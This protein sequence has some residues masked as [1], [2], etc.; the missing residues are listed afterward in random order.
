MLSNGLSLLKIRKVF[1]RPDQ[2]AALLLFVLLIGLGFMA[3]QWRY[4]ARVI[5]SNLGYGL[6][7]YYLA[8]NQV[9][10][11]ANVLQTSL[12]I[13]LES[14]RAYNDLGYI[15]YRRGRPH[16]AWSAFV[17]A[18]EADPTFS[19]AYNNL[20]LSYLQTGQLDPA[21]QALQQAIT[22]NPENAS[23]WLNLGIGEQRAG[24][25]Q[26]AIRAYRSALRLDP[27]LTVAQ[28]NLGLIYFAEGN[29]VEAEQYLTTSLQSQPNLSR[30]RIFRGAIALHQGD[31]D[32]AWQEFQA[33]QPDLD[34]DP[35]LHFYLGLWYEMAEMQEPA[36]E[37]FNKVLALNPNG[38]LAVLVQSHL[39]VLTM[40]KVDN[41]PLS[42]E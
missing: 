15:Y 23:A 42:T 27:R 21:R 26:E 29:F 20:G 4:Q 10:T 25:S 34:H 32:R 12:D 5:L 33:V 30:L 41:K 8:T 7:S 37:E 14:A 35:L 1:T 22:F 18:T 36:Q 38:E 16:E 31:Q 19:T 28:V 24:R 40:S 6:A 9:A 17:Q 11:A 2:I 13:N 39:T 3:W